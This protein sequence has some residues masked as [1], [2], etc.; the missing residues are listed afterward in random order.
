[1][2]WVIASFPIITVALALA[3]FP[4]GWSPAELFRAAVFLIGFALISI[5]AGVE[6]A[7]GFVAGSARRCW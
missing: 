2:V 6:L 1:M 3:W 7:I 5:G 4:T